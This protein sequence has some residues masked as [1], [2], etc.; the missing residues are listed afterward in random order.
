VTTL[1]IF[2]ES[3]RT[4]GF[5]TYTS[6]LHSIV[7]TGPLSAYNIFFKIQRQQLIEVLP[8]RA[9]GKPRR[10]HGK[11]GFADM[12]RTIAFKWKQITTHDKA[13]FQRL[14]AADKRRYTEEMKQWKLQN[15]DGSQKNEATLSRSTTQGL[16]TSV[17]DN[18]A[19]AFLA[20]M[21]AAPKQED[22]PAPS[23]G[24][25]LTMDGA[26]MSLSSRLTGAQ[27]QFARAESALHSAQQLQTSHLQLKQSLGLE[28]L[29]PESGGGGGN[30]GTMELNHRAMLDMAISQSQMLPL[31]VRVGAED[32]NEAY[33]T[34]LHDYY[35]QQQQLASMYG[36]L[37]PST[38]GHA[39]PMSMPQGSSSLCLHNPSVS[40][41]DSMQPPT[42]MASAV[43]QQ[44]MAHHSPSPPTVGGGG[45]GAGGNP[46][47]YLANSI[48][49]ECCEFLIDIFLQD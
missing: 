31:C 5:S 44:P 25:S 3:F 6:F 15:P 29:A 23:S 35:K 14:A 8:V 47:A 16:Q 36:T 12:A 27:E 34:F 46:I 45:G 39:L 32:N 4:A 30:N 18:E 22:A 48:G 19:V 11:I 33:Q 28:T 1:I 9:K 49:P 37:L 17:V 10:S 43:N 20:K 41:A 38:M 2:F 21:A 40:G 13:V 26:V 24:S 42:T 7:Y